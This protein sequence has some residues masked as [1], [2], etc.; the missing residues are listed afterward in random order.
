MRLGLAG[1]RA[2]GVF[3]PDGISPNSRG[4]RRCFDSDLGD[5]SIIGRSSKHVYDCLRAAFAPLCLSH[6]AT[7]FKH[8]HCVTGFLRGIVYIPRKL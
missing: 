4:E 7:K 6:R 3:H 2:F 1:Y 5:G 8:S